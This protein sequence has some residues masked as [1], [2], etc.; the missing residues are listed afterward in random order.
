[1]V[2]LMD[3]SHAHIKCDVLMQKLLIIG[4]LYSACRALVSQ[5]G[6]HCCTLFI[7]TEKLKQSKSLAVTTV[8][9]QN[10]VPE[11]LQTGLHSWRH[12]SLCI[13]G[14]SSPAATT[15]G[16][17]TSELDRKR[18]EESLWCRNCVFRSPVLWCI[19]LIC[20][21]KYDDI[22]WK[23]WLRFVLLVGN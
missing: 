7:V 15:M 20:G 8:L 22:Q 17:R 13:D 6:G 23:P 1:M 11:L 9:I 4:L 16:L 2:R 21:Y 5:Q 19:I 3:S 12:K 10:S 18:M 14:T